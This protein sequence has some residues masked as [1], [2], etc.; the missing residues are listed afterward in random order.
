MARTIMLAS[1][2]LLAVALVAGLF[3]GN[4]AP[5]RATSRCADFDGDG[6]VTVSDI[7]QVV[8]RFGQTPKFP[9]WDPAYDLNG[10]GV[11]DIGDVFATVQQFG[12]PCAPP[13]STIPFEKIEN[14]RIRVPESP[15]IGLVIARSEEEWAAISDDPAPVDFNLEIVVGVYGHFSMSGHMLQIDRIE[16]GF[17]G[18]T[19]YAT[20]YVPGPTCIVP[21][22]LS[23]ELHL[24]RVPRG[25]WL[26]AGPDGP[27]E[28]LLKTVEVD[29]GSDFWVAATPSS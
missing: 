11:V 14:V 4:A 15:P 16:K 26:T 29:C 6:R 24:V 1:A 23:T 28:L 19:V 18:A 27:L 22:V 10:N 20:H 9:G 25:F 17:E 5:A 8:Q 21:Q 7:F 2:A 13:G 12:R 3:L